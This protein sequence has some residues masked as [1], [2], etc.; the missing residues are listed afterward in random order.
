[1]GMKLD[2]NEVKVI[3]SN[4]LSDTLSK[5]NVWDLID[6]NNGSTIVFYTHNTPDYEEDN[7]FGPDANVSIAAAISSL[8]RI[9]MM[10][11]LLDNTFGLKYIDTDGIIISK[12]LDID[13]LLGGLK[14]EGKL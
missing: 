11:F 9:H 8:G 2:I 7:L 5:Y 13:N 1:M 14:K 10:P 6:L 3:R 4:D 12:I